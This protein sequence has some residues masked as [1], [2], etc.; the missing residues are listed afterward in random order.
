MFGR[1][2]CLVLAAVM[3]VP[4][5]FVY[6]GKEDYIDKYSHNN[7]KFYN[8]DECSGT[9]GNSSPSAIGGKAVVSGTT[10]KEKIWSGLK[11]MGVSDE[12]AAGIMGNMQRESGFSPARYEDAHKGVWETFDWENDPAKGHGVGLIQWSGGRRVNL[13]KYTRGINTYLVDEYLKKP[14]TYAALSGDDFIKAA[15]NTEEA[16]AL[17]SIELTF[18]I[19]EM[20]GDEGYSKVFSETTVTGAAVS[21]S[22]NVEGCSTCTATSDNTKDRREYAEAIFINQISINSACVFK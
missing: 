13:F 17:Y 19:E 4:Q 1:I 8:P 18:L 2:F 12:I 14:S 20:K 21:F 5:G 22:V 11:S 3:L 16:N 10:A 7:I 9:S 15:K 6:A